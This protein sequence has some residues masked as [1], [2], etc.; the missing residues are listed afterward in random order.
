[1]AD[2]SYH[3]IDRQAFIKLDNLEYNLTKLRERVEPCKIM[4]VVK[5]DAYGHG[6]IPVTKRLVEKGV[7]IFAVAR[8]AEAI[9]LIDNGIKD[10]IIIFGRLFPR[11]WQKAISNDIIITLT[12]A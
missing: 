3:A 2:H 10:N 6:V 8:M 5:A 12:R 7:E 1:M 11:E 4:A 9:E